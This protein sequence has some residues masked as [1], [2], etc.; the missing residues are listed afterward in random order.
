MVDQAIGQGAPIQAISYLEPEE[1][2]DSGFCLFA[3]PP[4][5]D[6]DA[7]LVCI[8]CL[9]DQHPKIGRPLELARA[10]GEWTSETDGQCLSPF[11]R[12]FVVELVPNVAV[13]DRVEPN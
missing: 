3:G 12:S 7:E 2:W 8:D 1:S 4:E 6:I 5:Q 13:V 10:N 11:E 9:L